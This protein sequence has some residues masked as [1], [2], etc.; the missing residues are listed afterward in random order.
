MEQTQKKTL[1]QIIAE[2]YKKC[3]TDPVHFMKK[4]CII[5]HPEKGKINFN[6]YDFQEQCLRDFDDHRFTI[7]NKGRQLGISTLAAGFITYKMIFNSDFNVLVIAT[8]QEVA[9]NLVTKVRVMHENLPSWL[10]GKTVEDNKLSLRLKNGSQVKAV[11]ASPDAGRSEALSLLVIDEAAHIDIIDD[12]WTAAQSTLATGGGAILLSSPNGTGNLFHKKWIEAE[13]GKQFYPIRLP[14]YVH[15]D[16]DQSWRDAQDDLLGIQM[17]AQE[18]DCDFVTSGHTVIDGPV[19]QWYKETHE[20]EPIER[21]G[22]DGNYWIWEYPDY[23]KTYILS[24]DVARGDG[25]DESAFIVI[26][27]ENLHQVAEY[28]GAIGTT[29]FGNM[30]VSAATEWNN[31]LLVIDNGGVGWASVQ[32]AIDRNY[33]NLFYHYSSDAY[34]DEVKHLNK[35]YDMYDRTKMTPGVSINTRTRPVMIS[36]LE[37][38]FRERTPVCRSKRSVDEFFTFIW[39]NGKAQA[40]NGYRDDLTMCWAMGFWVRDTALKL[41]QQGI[42]LHRATLEH[43][44]KTIYTPNDKEHRQWVQTMPK[45]GEESLK[46]LL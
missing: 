14:W 17:A 10:K 13:A 15:P 27:V 39:K 19:I 6:L 4:Y 37:T 29:D 20:T 22:F 25:S 31:A 30:I 21:R 35:G 7:I 1:K 36:K 2:E 8:K 28:R 44:T 33:P 9:K 43:F 45:G 23:K 12:I 11:A 24:A 41:R 40:Q 32:V 3:S 18:N 46:W 38:Y 26:D 5:Q 42:D 16:R 34:V